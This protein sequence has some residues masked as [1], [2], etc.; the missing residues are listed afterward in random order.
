M[1]PAASDMKLS[2]HVSVTKGEALF[3]VVLAA[4]VPERKTQGNPVA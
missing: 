3:C 2:P 4:L 1:K